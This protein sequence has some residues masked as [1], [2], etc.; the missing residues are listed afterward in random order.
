MI[1]IFD[2]QNVSILIIYM[3]KFV[4]TVRQLNESFIYVENVISVLL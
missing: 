1:C 4:V 3:I 2:M